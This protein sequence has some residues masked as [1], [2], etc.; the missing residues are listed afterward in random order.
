MRQIPLKEPRAPY[1]VT[2][3]DEAVSD[4]MMIVS[5]DGKPLGVL[6]PMDEYVAFKAWQETHN[7]EPKLR[8]EP[9]SLEREAQAYEGL[10]PRLLESHRGR[11]VAVH[12]EQIVEVGAEGE[13]LA[14]LAV[15]VY[16]RL[17]YVPIYFKRVEDRPR[18]YKFPY[19]KVRR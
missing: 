12:Q 18:V 3:E 9:R 15:R 8:A 5:H 1:T 11:T 19:F 10:K 7:G 4:E 16:K 13:S 6:V 2:L 17:G 14:D